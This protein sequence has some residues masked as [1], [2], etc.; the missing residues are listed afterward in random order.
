[1]E[2][3]KIVPGIDPDRIEIE[4]GR[5]GKVYV[6]HTDE[7]VI[8]D[9]YANG[10]DELVDTMTIWDEDMNNE[11]DFTDDLPEDEQPDFG[12]DEDD[13]DPAGGHGLYSHI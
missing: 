7:G 11:R 5:N 9:V 1:M 12:N 2:Y 4:C 3:L 8:I 6:T 13:I 10:S